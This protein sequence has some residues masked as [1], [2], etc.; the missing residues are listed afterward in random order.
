MEQVL[1]E[2]VKLVYQID[3]HLLGVLMVVLGLTQIELYEGHVV[4]IDWLPQIN[5]QEDLH[6]IRHLELGVVL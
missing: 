5:R 2:L 6:R 1:T 3:R 4:E